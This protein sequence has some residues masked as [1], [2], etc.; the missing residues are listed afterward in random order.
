MSVIKI[1][2][3]YGSINYFINDQYIAYDA[4]TY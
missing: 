4:Y 2:N 1:T 3:D